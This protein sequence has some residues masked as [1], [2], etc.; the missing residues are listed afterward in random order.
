MKCD[1]FIEKVMS[2][3]ETEGQ[4]VTDAKAHLPLCSYEKAWRKCAWQCKGQL[5]VAVEEAVM[6]SREWESRMLEKRVSAKLTLN[7]NSQSFQQFLLQQMNTL[8]WLLLWGNENQYVPFCPAPVFSSIHAHSFPMCSAS[9]TAD[10]LMFFLPS[11]VPC[12]MNLACVLGPAGEEFTCTDLI[13]LFPMGIARPL[14][15]LWQWCYAL[16]LI[17]GLLLWCSK[18]FVDRGPGEPWTGFKKTQFYWFL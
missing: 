5:V 6:K 7:R 15:Q 14:L 4:F 16:C 18:C 2:E 12:S 9:C 3:P 13:L 1:N 8:K 17:Y 10:L 11:V